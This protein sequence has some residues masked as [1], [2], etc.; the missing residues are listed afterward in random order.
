MIEDAIPSLQP[1]APP[2]RDWGGGY[3]Q[4]WSKCRF[5][6]TFKAVDTFSNIVKVQICTWYVQT[7]YF[8]MHKITTLWIFSLN[9][10]SKLQEKI[11][12]QKIPLL[13]NLVCF[14]MA[15]SLNWSIL[16]LE[17]ENYISLKTTYTSEGAVSHNMLYYQT[18]PHYSLL[19]SKFVC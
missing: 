11:E 14:Q 15:K 10:S 13:H 3:Y 9:W 1:P 5:A 6:G 2:I 16:L 17:W 8:C 4:L 12:R 7:Y 18:A 19:S